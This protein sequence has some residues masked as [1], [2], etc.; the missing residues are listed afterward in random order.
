LASLAGY[1]EIQQLWIPYIKNVG[2]QYLDLCYS[3]GL[4][5]D[6]ENYANVVAEASMILK[7][8]ETSITYCD[9]PANPVY[10]CRRLIEILRRYPPSDEHEVYLG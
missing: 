5:V 8:I 4:K 9:D 10:R 7:H 3:G 6:K 2:L 1:N